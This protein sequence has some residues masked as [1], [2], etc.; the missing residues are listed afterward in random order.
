MK[1]LLDSNICIHLLRGN[2]KIANAIKEAGQDNCMISEITKAELLVGVQRQRAKGIDRRKQVNDL[3]ELF[4]S[5]PISDSI[6]YFAQ[7]KARLMDAGTLI[8]DFDLMIG[9]TAV[10]GGY[11]LVSQDKGHLGRISGIRLEDWTE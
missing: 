11:V 9:C 2:L 4:P 3:L 6:E 1:Y 7:E 5:I 10:I 8:E